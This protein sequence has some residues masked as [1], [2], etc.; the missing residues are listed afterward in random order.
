VMNLPIVL[1]YPATSPLLDTYI[2]LSPTF[3][4]SYDV[5]KLVLRIWKTA[6][7]IIVLYSFIFYAADWIVKDSELNGNKILRICSSLNS[8]MKIIPIC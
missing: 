2:L 7:K 8:Y 1:L 4:S 5:R 3:S 6:G